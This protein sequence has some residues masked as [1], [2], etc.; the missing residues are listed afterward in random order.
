VTLDVSKFDKSII[1]VKDVQLKN[2]YDIS[3]ILYVLKFVKFIE[4][5]EKQLKNISSIQ[6][7]FVELK[8]DK[9]IS[10]IL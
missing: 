4:I 10:D 3:D 9:S 2:K 5:N 6:K 1:V 8:F 7:T